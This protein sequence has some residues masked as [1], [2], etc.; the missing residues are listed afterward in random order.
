MY[1]N[2]SNYAHFKERVIELAKTLKTNGWEY[3]IFFSKLYHILF[4]R[5]FIM[6]KYGVPRAVH[7]PLLHDLHD[8]WADASA[9]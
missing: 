2:C 9:V 8:M 1:R 4:D 6:R 3:R 5:P 7:L